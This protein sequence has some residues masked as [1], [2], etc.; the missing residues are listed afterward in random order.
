MVPTSRRIPASC[1]VIRRAFMAGL[2]DDFDERPL[3]TYD[4]HTALVKA[5]G[6]PPVPHRSRRAGLLGC[7]LREKRMD[8]V[9]SVPPGPIGI[10][11]VKLLCVA[12][13]T[14]HLHK[15]RRSRLSGQRWMRTR[16]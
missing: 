6:A 4:K 7:A 9:R 3:Y 10:H 8:S 12:A 1:V 13:V 2:L 16:R 5:R 14:G 11:I 15:R